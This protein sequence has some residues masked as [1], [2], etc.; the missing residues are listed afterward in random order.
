MQQ[1]G[2]A[3]YPVHGHNTVISESYEVKITPL[4]G[5]QGEIPI[6]RA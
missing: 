1:P 4:S 5:H 3:H 2:H 6:P